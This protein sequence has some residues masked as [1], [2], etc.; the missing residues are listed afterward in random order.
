MGVRRR[1]EGLRAEHEGAAEPL[2]PQFG[3]RLPSSPPFT[4]EK[5]GK[6]KHHRP[7]Q[8]RVDRPGA[9]MS[10]DRQ[11]LPLAVFC[12]SA[13]QILWA[14]RMVPK[15]EAGRFRKGPCERRMAA[16]RAGGARPLPR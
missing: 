12:L 16:L 9:L 8:H 7:F 4:L 2:V 5:G 14:R 11:R 13:G 6:I 15:E 3:R 1:T 10:Q